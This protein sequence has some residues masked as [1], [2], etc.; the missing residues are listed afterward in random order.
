MNPNSLRKLA[1][2]RNNIPTQLRVRYSTPPSKISRFFHAQ[3]RFL[4]SVPRL[5]HSSTVLRFSLF[6]ESRCTLVRR[7]HSRD[8]V[9]Y[10]IQINYTKEL[11]KIKTKFSDLISLKKVVF[12]LRTNTYPGI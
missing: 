1:R 7:I 6:C 9:R 5:F 10:G 8:S 4:G 12:S 11:A 3:T 2:R